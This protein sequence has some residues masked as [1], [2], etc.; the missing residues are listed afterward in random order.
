MDKV[1][2]RKDIKNDFVNRIHAG[3]HIYL[4]ILNSAERKERQYNKNLFHFNLEEIENLMKSYQLNTYNSFRNYAVIIKGYINYCL[5]M[6]YTDSSPLE[7]VFGTVWIKKLAPPP[8]KYLTDQEVENLISQCKNAQDAVII[9]L[10]FEGICGVKYSEILNL[11][12]SDVNIKTGIISLNNNGLIRE[13]KVSDKCIALIKEANAQKI[14]LNKNG[15]AIRGI[16][17]PLIDNEF[18]VRSTNRGRIGDE[19]NKVIYDKH[20]IHRRLRSLA[21]CL[22]LPYS[23]ARFYTDSGKIAVAKNV[24]SE[25]GYS[26]EKIAL[27][28]VSRIFNVKMVNNNGYYS[29][30]L[31]LK[32]LTNP[33][34]IHSIYQ[35]EFRE[36]ET[37]S[38]FNLIDEQLKMPESYN[39]VTALRR[40][41]QNI[42]RDTILLNY[43]GKCCISN[44][45]LKEVLESAHIQNYINEQSHHPQNG[46]C[47][48]SDFHKLF[49]KGLITITDDYKIQVS[50]RLHSPYYKTFNGV[51]I[52]LPSNKELY[53]SKK[54]LLFHRDKVFIE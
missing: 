14:Y 36:K 46:L 28:E 8:K 5:E 42:F 52:S 41:K 10:L 34:L 13:L 7:D 24:Y 43:S 16:E 48:R 37:V 51:T 3:G 44:E 45:G 1:V 17:A 23:N 21:E 18:V 35:I 11:R 47:L 39:E 49:D 12:I 6:G 20:L 40:V 31:T 26:A 22:N 54:A 2:I 4:N 19:K 29:Y 15:T 33:E 53:P 30:P 38:S 9:R 27:K 32:E 50:S 25:L